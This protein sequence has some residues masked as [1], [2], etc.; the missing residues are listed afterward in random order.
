MTTPPFEQ[1]IGRVSGD[2]A[3]GPIDRILLATDGSIFSREP[4]AVVYPRHTGDV[5]ETVAFAR[6]HGLSVHPRGAGSGLCGSALGSGIVVDFTRYMNRLIHIDEASRTFSC[7]P[8]YRFGE[9][10]QALKGRGLFFPP[11]P[12]SGEYASFGGMVGTNASGAHSVKYGNVSD[13]LLDAEVVRATGDIFTL[14]GLSAVETSALAA[15]FGALADLYRENR[16]AIERAYPSVR[17]N[18]AGYNLRNMV[19]NDRLYLHKLFAGAEGTL[20]IATRLT[21]RLL[22][23]PAHDSLVVAYFDAIDKAALA[24]QA[25]LP[26]GPAGIEV[27]D[28]SLLALARSSDPVLR[29]RIPAGIDN[30]L[31]VAFDGDDPQE[32]EAR[33]RQ[34][35][36][37]LGEQD[38]SDRAYLAVSADEK[39]RFWAVRKAAVPIL[40]KLKGEK[41]ILALI[42]DAAVPTD[43]LVEYFTGIYDLLNRHGVQFVVYGHIA[44]GLLHTRPLLNLKDPADIDLLKPLADGVFDLVNGLGGVVSGEHGDGRLRST[45]VQRQYRTI[46]PLFQQVR[47]LLDPHGL[48]NPAIK[49]ASTPDQMMRHLRYGAGYRR[50]ES[51][52]PQLNWEGGWYDEIE[53]CHGCTKCTT[54]TTATR[55]CP[56]YKFT[57]REAASPKAKA[58]VL[59]AL[60]SG[61]LDDAAL[62]EKAFQEVMDLCVGCGSCRL[63]CPSHVDIPKMALEARA[64]Y[65]KRFG[66][67]VHGRLVSSVETL[68]RY[69][70]RLSGWLKPVM[71]LKL[72][73]RAGEGIT[74]ISRRRPFVPVARRSLFRQVDPVAGGGRLQVLYF[75]GCYAGYIRPAIG[76]ALI[77]TL[78]RLGMTVHTPPQHCCGLPLLT[79]GR[80]DAAREKVR[81]NLDRWRHLL[82]RVDHIVVTCSS[83]GLALMD[84]WSCL[85]DGP[86]IRR[87]SGKVIHASRLIRR[88][89]RADRVAARQATVAYHQPCHLKVQAEPGSTIAMLDALP[90]TDVTALDSHCCGMAGTW[91]LAARNDGLSRIIGSHL[92]DLLDASGADAAVTDCPTCEMQMAQLGSR[93]VLHP[94][95]LVARCIVPARGHGLR[96]T[97]KDSIHP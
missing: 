54:V 31:L 29:E 50:M 24:V 5:V 47:Q 37:L 17:Y 87:V 69:G 18:V 46:F 9:L 96:Q 57:R 33:C 82:D 90:G 23:R 66:P 76:T 59:R 27:M 10:A 25:I 89:L 73:R 11:D 7:E 61:V 62:Y 53:R 84:E 97:S 91:G 2:V 1:L 75:S 30:V 38:L 94:V 70:G 74:G 52:P 28:K 35:R 49:T 92:M 80:V 21:F 88:Y 40:Y 26:M 81:R 13:Y 77:R 51:G 78:T 72:F 22:D 56:I 12:S 39:A 15:P 32:T 60:I 4:A 6:Q 44:K 41:K 85:M 55:M 86:R 79:K 14:S 95:E 68:G 83:C 71:D 42:E 64:R 48:M 58:N 45:Y 16:E 43:R 65:V 3:R 19:Q 34:V 63:E 67:S 8:G 20:G 36:E 93:P